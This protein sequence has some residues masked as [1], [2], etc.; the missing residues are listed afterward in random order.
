MEAERKIFD[1][2]ELSESDLKILEKAKNAYDDFVVAQKNF[3]AQTKSG[4]SEQA[5]GYR[6]VCIEQEKIIENLLEETANLD[7]ECELRK[8]LIDFVSKL[9]TKKMEGKKFE[10]DHHKSLNS[11]VDAAE[12]L[13]QKFTQI[14][15]VMTILNGLKTLWMN[16]WEYSSS[17]Y[18]SLNEIR[19]VTGLTEVEAE[20]L[21]EEYRKLAKEMSLSSTDIASGAVEFWRQGLGEEDVSSRLVETSKYAKISG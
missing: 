5:E 19:I 17:Y 14:V 1:L 9:N 16:A 21:G 6:K 8:R 11:S 13:Y 10:D 12:K 3:M 20:K 18:D 4:N 2:S 15:S 7:D